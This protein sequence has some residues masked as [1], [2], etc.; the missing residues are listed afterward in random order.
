MAF[1]DFIKYSVRWRVSGGHAADL[2][3]LGFQSSSASGNTAVSDAVFPALTS[4]TNNAALGKGALKNLTSGSNNFAI[5]KDAGTDAVVNVTTQSNVGV[6]GNNSTTNLYSKV[7]LTV[8]SDIRDK[9][10][11]QDIPWT[12]EMFAQI[13]TGMYQFRDRTTGEIMSSMRYGFSA[14]NLMDVEQQAAKRNVLV[15][16]KDVNHLKLNESMMVPVLVKMVQTL[17]AEVEQLK[18]QLAARQ[19]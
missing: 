5:G 14:Q 6:L 19:G 18:A 2:K 12:P 15:D 1:S 11:F 17:F 3:L 4:G 13:K 16:C 8:T 9:T 10:V 7:S